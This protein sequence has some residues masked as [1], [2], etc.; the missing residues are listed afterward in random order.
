MA[1][2]TKDGILETPE[3]YLSG[4]VRA[5]LREAEALAPLDKDYQNNVEELKKVIPKDIP[6]NDIYVAVGSPWIPN[7]VYA[8]FVAY[9]LGGHNNEGSYRGPDVTVGKTS[10][11]DF[12]I[13]IN[14]DA[15]KR[16]FQNT[17]KWGT[18]RKSFLDI[19]DALM[20][21]TSVKV[22]DYI[23]DEDGKR[24]AVLN[25]METAAAQEKAEEI[26]KEFQDWLWRDEGPTPKYNGENLTVNGLNAAFNLR[27]H[28]A[29][30][31]QRI[32]S[33][34]GNTLLAH[35]VGAGKTLE[36]A[37]AAMKL[38]ELG[39]VKKPMFVVP[40]ALVAQWGV[41]F[42]KYFPAAKLL[43]S[44]EK[45]FT[46]ANRKTYSNRIANGD[47]DAVILSYEQF[48]KIPMSKKYLHDFYQKQID[49]VIAAIA[50]EKS[51]SR[52]WSGKKPSCKRRWQSLL[53]NPKTRTT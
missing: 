44:D 18:R 42:K 31:V 41:E 52:K 14:N 29:N 33:S 19:M 40:K 21:S 43:V 32:I 36:M 4:N 9:M 1:F 38:R 49:E 53:P 13:V 2:K 34:G 48:E 10:S 8:D 22:N 39:I 50:E 20:S 6:F 37:A 17:Q 5:K 24:K 27:S 3:T 25:K 12:K 26:S 35:R 51:P 7:N 23:E 28:Q 15:L 11:G 30:A 47:Y 45:S 46:K 16:R